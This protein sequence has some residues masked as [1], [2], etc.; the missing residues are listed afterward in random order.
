MD[1]VT[2]LEIDAI[3]CWP[4][5]RAKRLAVKGKLP[6]Y[7][8]PD[9]DIRFKLNEVLPLVKHVVPPPTCAK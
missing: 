7:R 3:C 8:L 4:S 2:G 9:G 6:Y 1:L 5:G